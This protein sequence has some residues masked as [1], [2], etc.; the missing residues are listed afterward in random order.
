MVGGTARTLAAWAIDYLV[1]CSLVG[2]IGLA[3]IW[4]AIESGSFIAFVAI[5]VMLVVPF[6]VWWRASREQRQALPVHRTERESCSFAVWSAGITAGV[7]R[8]TTTP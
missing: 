7:G 1:L 6:I 3:T 4:P 2:I 5:V 8:D